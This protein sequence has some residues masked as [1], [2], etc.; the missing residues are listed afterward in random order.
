MDD[1]LTPFDVAQGEWRTVG[2]CVRDGLS[3]SCMWNPARPRLEQ[4]PSAYASPARFGRA[5][6]HTGAGPMPSSPIREE[7]PW[8]E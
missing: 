1:P 4:A 7:S 5:P 6:E 3:I 2:T 8:Y